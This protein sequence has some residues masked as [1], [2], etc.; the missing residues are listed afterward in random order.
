MTTLDDA[1]AAAAA[2]KATPIADVIE[3]PRLLLRASVA[4][5]H[6]ETLAAALESAAELK[7]WMPWAHPLPEMQSTRRYFDGVESAREARNM[8]DFQWIERATGK[9]VGKGGFHHLD[10]QLRRV[11]I[12]YWLRSSASGKGYCS[13]A[14]IAL[15]SYARDQLAAV[16]VEIRSAVDNGASRAVAERCG[17][18]FEGVLK[19]GVM[20]GDGS[21]I[22]GCL[23]AKVF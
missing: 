21:L 9:L 7:P 18:V 5:D 13:E 22:D 12:G 16:R 20:A 19:R 11:E 15:T 1:I 2:R 4:A 23:Y 3:T 8:I 17:Y 10:W 6:D 14:V